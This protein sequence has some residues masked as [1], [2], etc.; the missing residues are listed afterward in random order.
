MDHVLNRG[1]VDQIPNYVSANYVYH[2]ETE[3]ALKGHAVLEDHIVNK[4][5]GR[6]PHDLKR[7]VAS[8]DLVMAHAHYFGNNENVT[9]DWFRLDEQHQIAEHWSIAQPVVPFAEAA[10][11]HPH[12]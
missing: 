11:A 6:M 5:S 3:G 8:G 12:F 2:H 7:L 10:N 4:N 9:F 1:A